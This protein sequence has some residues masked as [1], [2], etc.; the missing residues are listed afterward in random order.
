LAFSFYE[1]DLHTKKK[2]AFAHLGTRLYLGSSALVYQRV[3]QKAP[4]RP[5]VLTLFDIDTDVALALFDYYDEQQ[6]Q[7]VMAFLDK[8]Q[9][10]DQSKVALNGFCNTLGQ[11]RCL[12]IKGS[13]YEY[14]SATCPPSAEQ[15]PNLVFVDPHKVGD[16]REGIERILDHCQRTDTRFLCWSPLQAVPDKDFPADGWSFTYHE[17]E[18]KFVETCKAHEY[19]LA[20]FAWGAVNGGKQNCYG[21]QLAFDTSCD[22]SRLRGV[23]EEMR[24]SCQEVGIRT[25]QGQ[26]RVRCWP[27]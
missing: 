20:W 18:K 27:E 10:S 25:Q 3:K 7:P 9:L 6:A 4:K 19:R 26:F 14:L 23:A 16:Q 13:S 12:V 21:C 2:T 8:C 5:L 15:R 11:P 1:D 17:D 24:K 22:V